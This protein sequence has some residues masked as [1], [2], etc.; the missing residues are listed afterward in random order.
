M[1]EGFRHI[2]GGFLGL[3]LSFFRMPRL[4]SSKRFLLFATA[5]IAIDGV[6]QT[7]LRLR[8][9]SDIVR[10]VTGIIFGFAFAHFLGKKILEERGSSRLG[11]NAKVAAAI[12]LIFLLFFSLFASGVGFLYKT[13]SHAIETAGETST[14]KNP[15]FIKAFYLP[16]K[17]IYSVPLD[18][19]LKNYDD[20]ILNDIVNLEERP[21]FGLW[22]VV[23]LEE[24]PLYEKNMYSFL[25][26]KGNIST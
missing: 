1:H 12:L 18:P 21:S 8:E 20:A 9:S 6:S 17:S 10:F 22:V 26:G 13:R 5:P 11:R 3:I 4:F 19:F 14:I 16:P 7:I 24:K 15:P 25:G 2:F 23:I